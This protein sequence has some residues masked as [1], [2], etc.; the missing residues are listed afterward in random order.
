M[1]A[2]ELKSSTVPRVTKGFWNAVEDI[3][4]GEAF[5]VAPVKDSYPLKILAISIKIRILKEYS[6]SLFPTRRQPCSSLRLL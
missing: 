5:V 2:V 3:A 6:A 1:P 4:P